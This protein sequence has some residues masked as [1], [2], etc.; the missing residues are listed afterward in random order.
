VRLENKARFILMVVDGK[1]VV[2][3][4]KKAILEEELTR[5]NFHRVYRG[6]EAS[7]DDDDE[8]TR[9]GGFDYLLSMPLWSLTYEKVL[10]LYLVQVH[11]SLNRLRSCA[12]REMPSKMN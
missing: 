5:L 7:N 2:N 4:K 3:R 1:L 11:S 9:S 12:R 10:L 8:E 6:K